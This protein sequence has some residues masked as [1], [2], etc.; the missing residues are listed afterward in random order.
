MSVW[1]HRSYD[2]Y[3]GGGTVAI[4]N[5]V[6]AFP[7]H[8]HILVTNRLRRSYVTDYLRTRPN[9]ALHVVKGG[10]F[11][12][13]LDKTKP[14]VLFFHYFPPMSAREFRDI[15]AELR[16]RSLLYNHWFKLVPRIP[17]L[18]GY[19]FVSPDSY[20]FTGAHLSPAECLVTYNP[21]GS[22]YYEIQ[23]QGGAFSIGR[24]SRSAGLKF[25]RDF[26]SLYERIDVDNLQVRILGCNERIVRELNRE[27]ARLRHTYWA[28]PFNS[29]PVDKF[30]SHLDVFVYK[31][32]HRCH[33]TG[34]ISVWEAMA[35][36]IPA[37]CE[38]KGSMRNQIIHGENGFLCDDLQ[39]FSDAVE[40]L[41]ADERLRRKLGKQARDWA[42]KNASIEVFRQGLLQFMPRVF[43]VPGSNLVS[44]ANLDAEKQ[45]EQPL[46][47]HRIPNA[48]ARENASSTPVMLASRTQLPQ[49]WNWLGLTGDGVF[50][51]KE[52]DRLLDSV[53]QAWRGSR[54]FVASEENGKNSPQQIVSDLNSI[55]NDRTTTRT[56]LICTA[57]LQAARNRGRFDFVYFERGCPSDANGEW[58]RWLESIRPAGILCG[59]L[60]R[61]IDPEHD[62]ELLNLGRSWAHSRHLTM[63]AFGG[64]IHHSWLIRRTARAEE[65]CTFTDNVLSIQGHRWLFLLGVATAETL[66]VARCLA[67]HPEIRLLPKEGQALTG[68]LPQPWEFG[69][70]K[71][72]TNRL[73]IFRWTES[74]DG[75]PAVR[76]LIDWRQYVQGSGTVTIDWSP[77]NCV[78]A[79]WLQ[80]HFARSNFIAVVGNPLAFCAELKLKRGVDVASSAHHWALAYEILS[81]DLRLLKNI[82]VIQLPELCRDIRGCLNRIANLLSLRDESTNEQFTQP[83]N[84]AE[85]GK[86]I[87]AMLEHQSHF[88]AELTTRERDTIEEIAA[89]VAA[90]LSTVGQ[91]TEPCH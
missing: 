52:G 33:E 64:R 74:M 3:C 81:Q 65:L 70:S 37:V 9:V 67:H 86:K 8:R 69:V 79:P 78:R 4:R 46:T 39:D 11:R 85:T 72:W 6:D 47:A 21:V 51:G 91:L 66:F 45:S 76:A 56:E 7:E 32:S 48:I 90:S 55:R 17:E 2:L 40:L 19:I 84:V 24:H 26:L 68:A 82:V 42:R 18:A 71:L 25:S 54:L 14:D 38:N 77:P 16:K 80:Q 63:D 83:T 15:P 1:F 13:I 60:P 27:G 61:S 88:V 44:A 35:A 23:K 53:Q 58:D 41:A 49:L 34:C 57:E 20:A 30:L 12:S 89:G 59:Q 50:V 43:A 87:G 73:D 36:G 62:R 22:I 5:L 75:I 31:T 28:L 29:M 10:E